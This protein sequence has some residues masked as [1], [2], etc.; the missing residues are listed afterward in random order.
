MD[1]TGISSGGLNGNGQGQ[2]YRLKFS[3]LYFICIEI[4]LT[5]FWSYIVETDLRR[6][7]EKPWPVPNVEAIM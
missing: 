7:G 5:T 1:Y 3:K 6:E 4:Y 2:M